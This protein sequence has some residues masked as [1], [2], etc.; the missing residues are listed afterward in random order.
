MSWLNMKRTLESL[1]GVTVTHKL[2]WAWISGFAVNGVVL[3]FVLEQPKLE[4]LFA[5]LALVV[6]F[7]LLAVPLEKDEAKK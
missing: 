1:K 2:V 3:G 6:T 5:A 4:K 7:M